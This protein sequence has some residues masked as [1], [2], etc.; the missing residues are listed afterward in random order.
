M[1]VITPI[2][3]VLIAI[4][5][6][7]W[8]INPTYSQIKNLSAE[9][10][11]FDMALTRSKELI[12][13]RDALL[14]RYNMIP[15]RDLERLEKLLPDHVDNVRLILDM[16]NIAAQYGMALQDIAIGEASAEGAELGADT[17]PIGAITLSFGVRSTYDNFLQFLMDLEESLRIV[18]VTSLSFAE[19][20]GTFTT[21]R[22]A[23]RTYW[24]K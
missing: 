4:G 5:V 8:Y 21:Y 2:V 14:S 15:T 23:L 17:S 3:L 6:F 7:I 10:E 12:A 22:V 1:R 13:V 19:G 11:Q 24:L 16:N 20:D 9:E 18:D